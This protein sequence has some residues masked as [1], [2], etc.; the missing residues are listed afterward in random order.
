M[1]L[2]DKFGGW[3]TDKSNRFIQGGDNAAPRSYYA[4]SE[5]EEAYGR[6]GDEMTPNMMETQDAGNETQRRGVDPFDRAG[7]DYGGRSVYK[8]Q[9]ELQAEQAAMEAERQRG[10]QQG[11]QP[12]GFDQSRQGQG[13]PPQGYGQPNYGGLGQPY[14]TQPPQGTMTQP[15]PTQPQRPTP[16]PTAPQPNNVV[17]FPGVRQTP[18]GNAFNHIEYLV[19]LRSRNECTK[20]IEYIKTNASVF[21][22]M[23]FIANDGER[24][25]CVDMLSGAAYT[26]GCKLNRISNRGMY[27]ISSPSVY[28]VMD[29]SMQGFSL[30]PESQGFVRQNYE[31]SGYG[32]RQGAGYSQRGGYNRGAYEE[33]QPSRF[34]PQAQAV[35]YPQQ[36]TQRRTSVSFGSMMAGNATGTY[37]ASPGYQAG[38]GQTGRFSRTDYPQ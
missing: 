30:A 4:S 15:Q 11:N 27:L 23:E 31:M 25:R 10:W 13:Q 16:Q 34:A 38:D 5:A 32:S 20:V 12:S 3:V 28:V 2:L 6:M 21:L 22:N 14:P 1:G 37:A 35:P 26:L 18:E 9:R 33:R 8:S 7:K 29:E 24:Q 19:L 17:N 36:N